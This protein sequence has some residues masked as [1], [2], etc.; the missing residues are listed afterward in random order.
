MRHALVADSLK[1]TP[2]ASDAFFSPTPPPVV[3]NKFKM[4]V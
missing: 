2:V 4:V 1:I 3:S